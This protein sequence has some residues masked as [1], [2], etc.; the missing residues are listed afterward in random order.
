[1]NELKFIRA[2]ALG[3]RHSLFIPPNGTGSACFHR[4]LPIGSPGGKH[5]RPYPA[6]LAP[7]AT[8]LIQSC[9]VADP[10]HIAHHHCSTTCCANFHGRAAQPWSTR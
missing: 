9:L 6:L 5:N 8:H 10:F 3:T 2:K 7:A 1:M 4:A